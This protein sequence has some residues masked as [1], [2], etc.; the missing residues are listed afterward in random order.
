MFRLAQLLSI[1][2]LAFAYA[3]SC[4][5]TTAA[6]AA[7]SGFIEADE[8]TISAEAAGRIE[9]LRVDEGVVIAPGDTVAVIDSSRLVLALEAARANRGVAMANRR[10]AVVQRDQARTA[11]DYAASELDRIERLVATNT[12][13]DQRRD[14]IRFDHASA[15]LSV[16]AAEVQ[17]ATVDAQL[18]QIDAEIRRLER[19][20]SDV[21]PTTLRAGTVLEVYVEAGELVARGA[22]LLRL[23][24]LDSV[25]V[26]VYLNAPAFASVRL[27][28]NATVSTE[29]GESYIGTVVRTADEA[30]FTPKNV[31]TAES[32]ADLVFAVKV[33]I[34]NDG[35][36]K[37]GMPVFVILDQD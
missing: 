37:I 13:T 2:T 19:D 5:D 34:P 15:R 23:A 12:A 32:R 22:P 35:R 8:I 24:S 20:L 4:S 25:W 1:V 11:L 7:G 29:T 31:Q 3:T 18:G 6:S 14:Q 26:N 21:V 30:E 28:Q 10:A 36:L 16:D 33:V 17:I 27:G 9:A